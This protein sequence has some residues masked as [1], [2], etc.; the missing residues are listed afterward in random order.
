MKQYLLPIFML[1]SGCG[2]NDSA[3]FQLNSPSAN[4]FKYRIGEL[5]NV[6]VNTTT[7]CR[8]YIAESFFTSYNHYKISPI[9]CNGKQFYDLWVPE[10]DISR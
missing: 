4:T 3:S 6:R 9:I 1:I 10:Y 5:V 2:I 8:G 7:I